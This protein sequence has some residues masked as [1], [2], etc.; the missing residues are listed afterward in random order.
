MRTA[1]LRALDT[2]VAPEGMGAFRVL[3]FGKGVGGALDGFASHAPDEP[4]LSAPLAPL[5]PLATGEHMPLGGAP[6]RMPTWEELARGG[7]A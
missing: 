4:R 7:A 1:N 3:A 6:Q 2:L 5:A